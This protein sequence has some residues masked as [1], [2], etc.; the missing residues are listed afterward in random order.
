MRQDLNADDFVADVG[1]PVVRL[2]VVVFVVPKLLAS[3][4]LQALHRRDFLA[5][6][7]LESNSQVLQTALV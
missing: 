6:C 3:E 5:L 2:A 1:K 7:C 4:H